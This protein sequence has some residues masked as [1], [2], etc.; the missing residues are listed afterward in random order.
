MSSCSTLR[1]RWWHYC[2]YNR[3][4]KHRS[5]IA[6]WLQSS[7]E[8][9]VVEVCKLVAPQSTESADMSSSK[10]MRAIRVS[11]F[12][13][14]SVLRLRSDVP[15]P[16]PGPRQVRRTETG[17]RRIVDRLQSKL[18]A[19]AGLTLQLSRFSADLLAVS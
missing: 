10:L 1:S 17:S 4:G 2:T 5:S 15:V 19:D 18:S 6:S 7:E 11:E 13:A 16:Q 8:T 3:C 14:P 9:F 12:G